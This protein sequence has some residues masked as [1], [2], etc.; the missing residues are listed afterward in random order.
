MRF[1]GRRCAGRIEAVRLLLS[2]NADVNALD[3]DGITPLLIA[4][5]RGDSAL[6]H[7]LVEHGADIDT[8]AENA[9]YNA[10]ML[11]SA[12]GDLDSVQLLLDK[13][14]KVN[15]VARDKETALL[16]AARDGIPRSRRC[17]WSTRPIPTWSTSGV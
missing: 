2:R 17:C 6:V 14:A 15:L 10:L 11:V 7:L 4:A 8:I 13:G 9:G 16:A 1:T 3:N 12:R 5:G